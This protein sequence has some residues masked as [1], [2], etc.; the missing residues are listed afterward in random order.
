MRI[1]FLSNF[2]PPHAIGGYEQWCQEVADR[3][4][5]RGHTVTVLTS[6]YGVAAGRTDRIHQRM[7][8]AAPLV[9]RTLHLQAD[10][11]YY[12]PA[13]FFLHRR[14]HERANQ[15]ALRHAIDTNSARY[16]D[17]VG[18]VEFVAQSAPLGGAVAAWP[19]GLFYFILLAYRRRSAHRLLAIAHPPPAW[20]RCSSSPY[21]VGPRP[22]WR[23]KIIHPACASNMPFVA[24]NMCAIDWC[25]PANYLH[26]R[27]YCSAAVIQPLFYT[28]HAQMRQITAAL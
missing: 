3:L 23:A 9:I 18:H 21:A 19:C 1:L 6:R 17:G 7:H 26:R 2:Y 14:S 20:Q 28:M 16:I 11:A 4:H 8:R 15:Q 22:N 5:A 25:K 13:D 27:G 24:A 12:Q 10:L